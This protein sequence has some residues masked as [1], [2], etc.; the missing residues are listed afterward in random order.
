VDWCCLP[1]LDSASCFGRLLDWQRGG[2]CQISP[3]AEGYRTR[4]R[5]LPSTL[6]LETCFETDE[7]EVRLLDGFA[8]RRGGREDPYRQL[9]RIVE[10]RRGTVRMRVRICPR[11]DYG[12]SRPWLRKHGE[13]LFTAIVDLVKQG[14]H[15]LVAEMEV[16][17]GERRRLAIAFCEPHRL[18][19][20]E[21]RGVSAVE[22][23]RRFEQSVEWWR[24]WAAKIERRGGPEGPDGGL[25]RS[26]LVLKGLCNALTGA[27]AAALTTSLPEAP[28]G[29][30]NWD[31]RYSWIRDSSFAVRSLA[32]L[33]CDAESA[34][35]QMFMERTTA[36][37]ANELQVMYGVGGEHVLTEVELDWLEGY[38]GARPVRMGNAAHNQLQLDMY[39]ELLEVAWRGFER[40]RE[41]DDEL[42]TFL[43]ALA[44]TAAAEW[45][46]P[47]YGIWEVRCEPQHFVHSKVM[48]WVALDRAIRLAEA[49]GRR[50]PLPPWREARDEV[51]RQVETY[52]YHP[53]RGTFV[54]AFGSREMDAALLLLPQV[55]FVAYD[56]ERMVRT[57]DAVREDLC[58][59][60]LVRRYRSPDGL[61]GEEGT[62]LACTFWLAACLAHQGRLDEARQAYRRA[63]DC[64]NDL[65]LFAEEIDPASGEMLGN[66]PQALS[67]YSHIIAAL[68]LAEA[69]G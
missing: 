50:A 14:E 54:Q 7:G 45:H 59:D 39:G 34:G 55:G 1:R 46:E 11:F 4:R 24:R 31:Y 43:C 32:R 20:G 12:R 13:G 29:V 19:P 65:G 18:Y 36:G 42:W 58:E 61:S 22:I 51:R 60:G 35:F 63:A 15:D 52:G 9:L 64:A 44:D 27:I 47:D 8:M 57:V 38:R 30:R 33:G 25:E 28:G 3:A 68:A 49:T 6:M 16:A 48:C 41:P 56:D 53:E 21:P 40:G 23:D 5:Y 2:L 37:G 66:F 67:H 62:F 26:A 69:E 17:A 10:G